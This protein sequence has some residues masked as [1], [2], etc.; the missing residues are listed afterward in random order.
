[1]IAFKAKRNV[2]TFFKVGNGYLSITCNLFSFAENLSQ[3]HPCINTLNACHHTAHTARHVGTHNKK[4]KVDC[5]HRTDLCWCIPIT[6]LLIY[7]KRLTY[8]LDIFYEQSMCA[9]AGVTLVFF[10]I[11][12]VN[13]AVNV[14]GMR[15]HSKFIQ[16]QLG[17]KLWPFY[18]S[19]NIVCKPIH[20]AYSHH[21]VYNIPITIHSM[22]SDS[23]RRI[24]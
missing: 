17:G 15:M 21:Y 22:I 6:S 9:R 10:I 7:I 13:T 4:N 19:H 14:N 3:I 8:E 12:F 11:F 5:A 24:W 20:S 2:D 1:M 16:F 23:C 18:T